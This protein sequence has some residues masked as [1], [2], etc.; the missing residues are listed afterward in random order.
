MSYQTSIEDAKRNA[1][2]FLK[3]GGAAAVK[4]EAAERF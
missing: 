4:L 2:R 1:G 3:E